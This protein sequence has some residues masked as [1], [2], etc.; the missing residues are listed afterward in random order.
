ME[1]RAVF[2]SPW[3]PYALVA[4]QIAITLIFFFLP[5]AQALYQSVL[6]QDAF[7]LTTEFVG[8]ENFRTLFSD[9][10]YLASFRVTV[11]FSVLV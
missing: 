11:V 4:P 5:A 6:M 10:H 3:L 8:L 1:K 7:G 2:R 9:P